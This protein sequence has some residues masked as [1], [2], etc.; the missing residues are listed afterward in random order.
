V[1]GAIVCAAAVLAVS[2]SVTGCGARPHNSD[3]VAV[4]RPVS[5]PAAA[6][7]TPRPS[8]S[9]DTG[10]ALP[11][12]SGPEVKPDW[13]TYNCGDAGYQLS[14]TWDT[15]SST[16]ATAHGTVNIAH[17]IDAGSSWSVHV[18]F[19]RPR[20]VTYYGGRSLFSR[21]VVHYDS[22]RGPDGRS[23]DTMDLADVWRS[24]VEINR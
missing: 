19:D 6:A 4:D 22:G 13:W 1:W 10:V 2:T 9:T 21:L 3:V 11:T 18:V 16:T 12:C 23:T 20:A 8:P 17:G 24:A 5:S 15:W 14:P 7:T